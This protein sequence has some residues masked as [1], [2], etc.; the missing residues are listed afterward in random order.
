MTKPV[1]FAHRLEYLAFRIVTSTVGNLPMGAAT[2]MAGAFARFV[3]MRT[4]LKRR[5]ERNLAYAMP[6]LDNDAR[7][8]ILTEM[9]DGLCR[10]MVEY[11][12]LPRLMREA[13]ERIE[14]V[15]LEHLKAARDA[16]KGAMLATG[17]FGN[18]E[19]IRIAFAQQG[20]APALIYRAF[21]NSLFD[22]FVR[23]MMSSIDA[24]IFHKG[25]RGSLGMLRHVRGGGSALILTDQRFSGAPEIPFFD[26]PAQTSLGAAEIALNYGAALM[27][28]RGERVGRT[29]RFRVVIEAPLSV[30]GRGAEDCTAEI[31]ARLESW[32]RARPEQYFWMHN[33]WGKKALR[34]HSS[35]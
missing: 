23:G 34:D 5:A 25:R 31:N 13:D 12:Y 4:S 16:G 8:S 24:P 1:K 35:E 11:R 27:P 7:K 33:R 9:F 20:W 17:H 10:T 21:N 28:V 19:I 22:D 15:G 14:I 32:V 29:G 30:E 2:R 18:W 26:H 6:D 3:G